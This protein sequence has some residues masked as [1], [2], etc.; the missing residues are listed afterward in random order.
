MHQKL[1]FFTTH[2]YLLPPLPSKTSPPERWEMLFTYCFH[3][4]SSYPMCPV[5]TFRDIVWEQGQKA[6]RHINNRIGNLSF[7]LSDQF[8]FMFSPKDKIL[9]APSLVF[10]LRKTARKLT[11]PPR[12]QHKLAPRPLQIARSRKELS[13]GGI[14]ASVRPK[15]TDLVN[16]TCFF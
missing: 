16:N 9:S 1:T 6:S 15:P 2:L 10:P 4:K 8:L 12:N 7:N 13:N 5:M 3:T 11:V 14:N